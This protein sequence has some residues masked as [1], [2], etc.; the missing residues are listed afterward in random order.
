M[1]AEAFKFYP[2]ESWLQVSRPFHDSQR[3]WWA[4]RRATG[5]LLVE[6]TAKSV[7][8]AIEGAFRFTSEAGTKVVLFPRVKLSSDAAEAL[9]EE[10]DLVVGFD[11]FDIRDGFATLVYSTRSHTDF[12]CGAFCVHHGGG[13]HTKAAG[14]SVSFDPD[15]GSQDPYSTFQRLLAK[16]EAK[17]PEKNVIY[18]GE[19]PPF[20]LRVWTALE[21]PAAPTTVWPADSLQG[22]RRL[23]EGGLVRVGTGGLGRDRSWWLPQDDQE[24]AIEVWL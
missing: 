2:A 16:Y 7:R 15:V 19:E 11:F 5:K 8:K 17:D 24:G 12:N 22:A 3:S 13:G 1:L 6:R 23:I 4:E 14:F 21:H 18:K 20:E 9:H 10:A